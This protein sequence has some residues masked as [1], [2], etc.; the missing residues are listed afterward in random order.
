[1]THVTNYIFYTMIKIKIKEKQTFP[2]N[3]KIKLKLKDTFREQDTSIKLKSHPNIILPMY[4]LINTQCHSHDLC[5]ND[6]CRRCYDRSF[7]SKSSVCYWSMENTDHPR[8]ITKSSSQKYWFNCPTCAHT[9]KRALNSIETSRSRGGCPFCNGNHTRCLNIDCVDCHKVSFANSPASIYWST[10]NGSLTP[11]DIARSSNNIVWLKCPNCS[12]DYQITT[13]DANRGR[14]CPYC[15]MKKLCG[16]CEQCFKSSFA[17]HSKAKYWS[18]RNTINP[19]DVRLHSNKLFWF[20]CSIC[21]HVFETAP[22]NI[23]NLDTWCP[24]CS[25][26]LKLLCD[27][28]DCQWCLEHSFASHEKSIYW[29]SKNDINPRY[30]FKCSN[31]DYIF[32]CSVCG[33]EFTNSPSHITTCHEWCPHCKNKSELKL[34]DWMLAMHMDVRHNVNFD[35]CKSNKCRYLP[36]DFVI[37]NLKLIIELDGR[38]HMEQVGN[39]QSPEKQQENDIYKMTKALGNGYSCI[40]ILQTDV[41][42]N[43]N[44]WENKLKEAIKSYPIPTI[45]YIDNG[46]TY[47]VYK[48]HFNN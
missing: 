39:W 13:N 45:I 36:I 25:S 26:P 27:D 32:N 15:S 5:Q 35:W 11:R 44:D 23:T 42:Y 48:K 4:Q 33:H 38:G 10:K 6:H 16:N 40:R 2:S 34:F 19:I 41:W 3:E 46:T 17:S 47:D 22:N 12:H 7:C 31:D 28:D 9:Y 30:V 1:M 18:K 21:N 37:E 29:S 43:R 20:E 14:R 8:M 24:Y